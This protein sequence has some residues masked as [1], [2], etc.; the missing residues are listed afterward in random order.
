[1]CRST[2]HTLAMT[3]RIKYSRQPS[4]MMKL[5]SSIDKTKFTVTHI[6][7]H[8][9]VV[10]VVTYTAGY[11]GGTYVDIALGELKCFAFDK[12]PDH[13]KVCEYLKSLCDEKAGHEDT[14]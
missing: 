10:K 4:E 11:S 7:D 6:G 9:Y 8:S 14:C 2:K 5:I 12:L 1:M 13:E 3:T